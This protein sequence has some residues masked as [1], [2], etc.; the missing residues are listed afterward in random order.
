MAAPFLLSKHAPVGP[1]YVSQMLCP[2]GRYSLGG[3]SAT[4]QCAPCPPGTFG[5]SAGMT[6]SS[7]SGPCAPGY[8]CAA[9][10][11]SPTAS[12]CSPGRFSVGFAGTCTSCPAGTYGD[13]QALSSAACSGVCAAGFYCLP[14]SASPTA[15]VCG[16]GLYSLAGAAACSPCAPGRYSGEYALASPCTMGCPVGTYCAGGGWLAVYVAYI[17]V[18]G[19]VIDAA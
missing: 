17:G 7:C 3:S 8:A 16:P 14:G 18:V 4:T 2:S 1:H 19:W 12:P 15:A 6:L 5:I 9:G 13:V 11:T 10:S